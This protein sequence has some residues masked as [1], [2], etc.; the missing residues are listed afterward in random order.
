M[1]TRLFSIVLGL[2]LGGCMAS[3]QTKKNDD[4]VYSPSY[5]YNNSSEFDNKFVSIVGWV[6]LSNETYRVWDSYESM[7]AGV[8]NS[9]CLG[10]VKTISIK[11]KPYDRKKVI[12]NGQFIASSKGKYIVLGGCRHSKII[13]VTKIQLH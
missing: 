11:H 6:E 7:Q 1:W 9:L 13:V 5:L 4:V 12:L 8:D 10:V 3:N 2:L